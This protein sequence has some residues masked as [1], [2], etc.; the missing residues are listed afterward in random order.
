MSPVDEAIRQYEDG[1]YT[2]VETINR[3]VF[4][5]AESDIEESWGLLPDWAQVGVE[6][7]VLRSHLPP[8]AV[9]DLSRGAYSDS[10]FTRAMSLLRAWLLS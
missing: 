4:L 10:E 3:L 1:L 8:T 6:C 5:L 9:V 2:K 7:Y